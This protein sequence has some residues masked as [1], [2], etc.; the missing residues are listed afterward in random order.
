VPGAA[1]YA[2][3]PEAN[4]MRLSFVT[5]SHQQIDTGMAALAL[6]IREAIEAQRSGQPAAAVQL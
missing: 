5:A 2:D 1:F 3:A 4:T 6:T